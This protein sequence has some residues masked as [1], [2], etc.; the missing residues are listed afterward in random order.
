VNWL[1][2]GS[3]LGSMFCANHL[4]HLG[5]LPLFLTLADICQGH[6]YTLTCIASLIDA[7]Y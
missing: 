4:V 7:M 3:D 2:I 1:N 5:I 6:K